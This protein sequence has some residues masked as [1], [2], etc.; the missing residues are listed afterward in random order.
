MARQAARNNSRLGQRLLKFARDIDTFDTPD[1]VLNA[2][3]TITSRECGLNVLG[4][5]QFPIKFG[6]LASLVRGQTIFLHA[7]APKNCRSSSKLLRYKGPSKV[8]AR[9]LRSC[10]VPQRQVFARP[11]ASRWIPRRIGAAALPRC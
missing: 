11:S 1:E 5:L 10:W 4:A 7:S 2:L 9:S 3:H 6:D 8:I